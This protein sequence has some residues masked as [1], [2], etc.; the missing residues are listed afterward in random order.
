MTKIGRNAPCPCGSGKKYK[1][2]CLPLK[3][4]ATPPP[5][6][7]TEV[8]DVTPE[9]W[10]AFFDDVDLLSNSVVDLI[11][12]GKLDEAE[13]SSQRLLKEF[14]EFVDGLQ[15]MAQVEEARGNFLSAA[16]YYRKAVAFI[17]D[18]PGFDP[19]FKNRLLEQAD[20]L[21]KKTVKE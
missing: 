2:C 4:S 15:R 18:N 11:K 16:Q 13:A 9:G 17:Q 5:Q 14:P 21:E 20:C 6:P 1:R 3:Q 8:I 12:V 10:T 19:E 7:E